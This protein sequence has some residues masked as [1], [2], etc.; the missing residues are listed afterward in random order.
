MKTTATITLFVVLLLGAA[1]ILATYKYIR[2][3]QGELKES[4]AKNIR[5]TKSNAEVKPRYIVGQLNYDI[6]NVP[7]I[8]WGKYAVVRKTIID[9]YYIHEA[10]IKVFT[11]KDNEFNK[12][13]ALELCEI[14]NT[15]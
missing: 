2:K 6:E 7:E 10:I 15:K 1:Y 9:G 5:C 8:Y 3:L 4:L 12:R 11:D 14:L 13:E